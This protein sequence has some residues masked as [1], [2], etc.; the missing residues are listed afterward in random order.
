MMERAPVPLGAGGEVPM[1]HESGFL[2]A[3]L[4]PDDR[5]ARL[6]FADWLDDHDDPRGEFLRLQAELA[7]WVPDHQRRSLLRQRERD[8]LERH[9]PARLLGQLLGV[10]SAW[11]YENGTGRV[12]LDAARFLN[13]RF[14]RR[15]VEFLR[16]AWV[17]TVRLEG[18][19]G[20]L[21]DVA[22]N[23]ALAAVTAL[24][25][26]GQELT[27]AHFVPLLASPYLSGLRELDLAN[28]AL[29][30][31]AL[32]A[33]AASPLAE[34]LTRLNLR[35]NELRGHGFIAWPGG[36][37]TRRCRIELAGNHLGVEAFE[38]LQAD[39]PGSPAARPRF[40]TVSLGVE[41][42]LVPAGSFLMG[43]PPGEPGREPEQDEPEQEVE[44]PQHEVEISRPFYLGRCHVTQEQY[45]RLMDANPSH[46]RRGG[47][48]EAGVG[49]QD[50]RCWPVEMVSLHDALAF[51]RRLSELPA[52]K[53]AGRV[54][55]LPT[56]AEWEHACRAGTT[57]PF[58]FGDDLTP[59]LARFDHSRPY[60]SGAAAGPSTQT[61][62]RGGAHPA[63]GFGLFDMH[64]NMW[65]WVADFYDAHYYP[66]SPRVDPPGPAE[67]HGY[68]V[69]RG[70]SW[71]NAAS[72]CRSAQ[73]LRTTIDS[74][75]FCIGF[76]VACPA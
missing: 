43:S 29:T 19:R 22:A 11:A 26:S 63:N 9:G 50:T 25:L 61:P 68:G 31:D 8:W 34:R 18:V 42:A 75:S 70:G 69:L 46:F 1:T 38:R 48:G 7:V 28:N 16:H 40:L 27:D 39:D 44:G 3:L 62:A 73:R 45:Q 6:I 23:P 20:R 36:F 74:G 51:C 71:F 56:E 55:R 65:D 41:L 33:L 13:P 12:T 53:A 4:D 35:N 60:W 14:A 76:R 67:G 24:D 57:S 59:A 30:D 5:A 21:G 15:G 47:P 10:C 58:A 17:R 32:R 49:G 72:Y 2:Q 66:R 52:E 64:G 37:R 54:Y